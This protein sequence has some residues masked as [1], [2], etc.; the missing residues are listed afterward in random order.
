LDVS[1]EDVSRWLVSYRSTVTEETTPALDEFILRAAGRRA[2]RVRTLRVSIVVIGLAAVVI[3]P[4]WGAHLI[5]GPQARAASGYG[6]QEGATRYYLL[7]VAS[8]TGPGSMEQK[9]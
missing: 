7:N 4:F 1:E 2:V 8:Y 9:Q 3:L 5:R 6:R